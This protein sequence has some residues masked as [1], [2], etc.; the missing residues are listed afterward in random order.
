MDREYCVPVKCDKVTFESVEGG[1]VWVFA[2]TPLDAVR[3]VE[4]MYIVD[5][6]EVIEVY[7]YSIGDYAQ[8][9]IP[10]DIRLE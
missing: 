10:A 7:D 6:N 5:D 4:L 3:Q 2:R 8:R 1:C 9:I